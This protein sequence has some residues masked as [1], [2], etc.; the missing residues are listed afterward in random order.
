MTFE[1]LGLFAFYLKGSE[2]CK[3]L[4]THEFLMRCFC[5]CESN[6]HYRSH[7]PLAW[8]NQMLLSV[9]TVT[10]LV[11][12]IRHFFTSPQEQSRNLVSASPQPSAVPLFSVIFFNCM[13]VQW[14]HWCAGAH[15]GR[16]GTLDSLELVFQ[17]TVSLPEVWTGNPVLCKSSICS[18]PLSS[19]SPNSVFSSF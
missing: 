1:R 15:R 11:H 17:A 16:K 14:A 2:G 19:L 6:H 10:L 3:I 7:K 5:P 13:G 9:A 12:Q 18:L 4:E 8:V